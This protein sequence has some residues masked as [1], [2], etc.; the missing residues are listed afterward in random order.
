MCKKTLQQLIPIE[1]ISGKS[2][3]V[4]IYLYVFISRSHYLYCEKALLKV[5][6]FVIFFDQIKTLFQTIH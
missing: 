2:A 5:F 4:Q 6:I 3:L 1:F